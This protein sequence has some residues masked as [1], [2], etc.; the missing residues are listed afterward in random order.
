MPGGAKVESRA[1]PMSATSTAYDNDFAAA[2][3]LEYLEEAEDDPFELLVS[4]LKLTPLETA[5]RLTSTTHAGK[6]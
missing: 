3:A 4:P 6:K 2:A 5:H 1:R